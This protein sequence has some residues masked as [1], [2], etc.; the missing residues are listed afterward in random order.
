MK[1]FKFP[2]A[3]ANWFPNALWA[4]F[5]FSLIFRLANLTKFNEL[6]FDEVYFAKY[7]VDYL[8]GISF[9]DAHPPLGKYIIALGIGLGKL[10][11]FPFGQDA[12]NGLT[13]MS[14]PVFGYRWANA[15]FGAGIPPLVAAIAFQISHK[16]TFALIAGCLAA[17]D[18]LLLVESRFALINVYA[19]FFGL[20][21]QW[22]FCR[23]TDAR[24]ADA[25][26]RRWGW[27]W[28]WWLAAGISL[29]ASVAVKWNGLGFWL[30]LVLLRLTA[31][32]VFQVFQPDASE[33]SQA[34][35]NSP[36]SSPLRAPSV[37]L[38]KRIEEQLSQAI[39]ERFQGF[40]APSRPIGRDRNPASDFF[41][42]APVA[43]I[44][45]THPLSWLFFLGLVPA[46]TYALLWIPHLALNPGRNAIELHQIIFSYHQNVGS[47]PE[48]HPYCSP[49]W[50][51]PLMWRP[52]GYFYHKTVFGDE[53]VPQYPPLPSGTGRLVHDV[54]A[55]GNPILWWFAIAALLLLLIA[56]VQPWLARLELQ[57]QAATPRDRQQ[58][59]LFFL[60]NY[61]ANWLPWALPSRCLFIYHYLPAAI[62]SWMA[63]AWLLDLW[64]RSSSTALQVTSFVA[65]AAIAAA[66]IFWLPIFLGWPLSVEAW[67]ARMWFPS[68]I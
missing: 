8:Q 60:L 57:S 65:I 45:R 54:H 52:V 28:G 31:L 4:L 27:R 12:T 51:W 67:R 25:P 15:F 19:I 44:A 17:L 33:R 10:L 2:F 41:T 50:S 6:V 56:V 68:W 48:T 43:R 16:R 40:T 21:G 59:A 9:F 24:D 3:I 64:L 18:G 62:F 13:G 38:E 30:G 47:D 49:W 1:D 37:P 53:A 23:G 32:P 11:P 35:P 22:L 20:L 5:F 66:F 36:S 61:A 29:G 42:E 58:V 7:A 63:L 34:A 46:I 14:V 26:K 39:A 55:M